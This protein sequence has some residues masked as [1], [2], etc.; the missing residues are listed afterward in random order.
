[1][2]DRRGLATLDDAPEIFECVAL[3]LGGT[4]VLCCPLSNACRWLPELALEHGLGGAATSVV[5]AELGRLGSVDAATRGE[6]PTEGT[7]VG[8]RDSSPANRFRVIVNG[9]DRGE[10]RHVNDHLGRHV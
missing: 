7:C 8:S 6:H 9:F 10:S 3:H 4:L 2:L 5:R 1:M